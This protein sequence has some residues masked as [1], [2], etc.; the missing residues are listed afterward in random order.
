MR[1]KCPRDSFLVSLFGIQWN[2]Q[3]DKLRNLPKN[4]WLEQ[5]RAGIQAQHWVSLCPLSSL[6]FPGRS[7]M[8]NVGWMC[9]ALQETLQEYPS[10]QSWKER[11]YYV[12][13]FK[14]LPCWMSGQSQF[15]LKCVLVARAAV[16]KYHSSLW[17][18][19]SVKSKIKVLIRVSCEGCEAGSFPSPC[20]VDGHFHGRMGFSLCMCLC[21]NLPFYKDTSSIGVGCT[22]MTS[23]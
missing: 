10:A 9:S 20:L 13:V 16:T 4:W 11:V 5:V 22:L 21:P 7:C 19:R 23:C 8:Q 18:P 1:C 3:P 15:L 12:F 2:G 6:G 14:A 17:S